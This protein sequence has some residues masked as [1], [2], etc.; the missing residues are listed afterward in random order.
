MIIKTADEKTVQPFINRLYLPSPVSH[1]GQNGRVLVIGG[2]KLF[3][4]ASIWAAEV[5]SHIVDIVHYASTEE[6]ARIFLSLKERFRNGIVVSRKD[7]LCYVNEDDAILIGPGMIREDVVK[8]TTVR[9]EDFEE[10]IRLENEAEYARGLVRYLI[11]S[12]PEKRFVF[13]AG[14]LQMMD[15]AWLL[16]L[17]TPPILTPHQKEFERVFGVKIEGMEE[18]EKKR[19]I[20]EYAKKHHC[21]ILLK[22]IKDYVSDGETTVIVEGGNAGLTK[23]GTG[24][25]LAGLVVSFYAK[26]SPLDA[27]VIASYLLKK[28][29][30]KLFKEKGYWYN[31]ADIIDLLPNTLTDLAIDKG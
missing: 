22:S 5:A 13:D 10:I 15:K 16:K 23:G 6:N 2:S 9:Y 12:F 3:H 31:I 19:V 28:T 7:L 25:V 30:D 27:G 17:K 14:A 24:D 4:A 26:N 18:E 1:K 29:A 8:N 21:V 11:D 20:A